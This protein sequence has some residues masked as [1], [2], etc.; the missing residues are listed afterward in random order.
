MGENLDLKNE[1]LTIEQVAELLQISRTLAYSLSH[2]HGGLPVVRLGRCLR[3]PRVALEAWLA[4]QA[5][6]GEGR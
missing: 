4:A 6:G 5:G 3:I 1:I 2:R